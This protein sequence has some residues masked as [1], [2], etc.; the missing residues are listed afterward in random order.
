MA[1]EIHAARGVGDSRGGVVTTV[2]T[3][4]PVGLGEPCFDK[5]EALL[6]HAM[7][8]LPATKGFEMGDGFNS[9]EMWG[10]DHNDR[11]DSSG[12]A[13]DTGTQ[14][15]GDT[16]L[17]SSTN[18]AGGTL[19]GITSGMPIVHRVAIKPVSSI[20]RAQESLTYTGEAHSVQVKGRH[21]PCV[22]PR[23]VPLTEAMTSVVIA[24]LALQQRSR[25]PLARLSQ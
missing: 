12:L 19:G 22:L 6:A 23:A 4:V 5:T 1:I 2:A 15:S 16:F 24:D 10:S 21:D 3:G 25:R 14:S 18:H 17:F 8:S 11:Y 9:V 7:M 20:S 13:L